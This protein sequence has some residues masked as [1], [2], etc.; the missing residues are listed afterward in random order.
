MV[1]ETDGY[2]PTEVSLWRDR[3][4]SWLRCLRDAQE[5]DGE[6]ETE[7]TFHAV[8]QPHPAV[9]SA[10]NHRK[11]RGLDRVRTHGAEGFGRTVALSVLAFNLHRLGRLL[12]R[13]RQAAERRRRKVA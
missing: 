13:K 10:I 2:D 3:L 4:R 5:G 9:G 7:E 11:H 12:R 8:R 6:R 1:V